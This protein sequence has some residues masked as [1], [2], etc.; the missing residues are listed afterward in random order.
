MAETWLHSIKA[1]AKEKPRD[2]G[3]YP[4]SPRLLSE[5]E[6]KEYLERLLISGRPDHR[7]QLLEILDTATDNTV[8]GI[9]ALKEA[10]P[11][12]VGAVM[13]DAEVT[14]GSARR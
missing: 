13:R 3:N 9:A 5:Q 14:F 6:P 4:V 2:D 7:R 10:K 12:L 11:L 8:P 1:A